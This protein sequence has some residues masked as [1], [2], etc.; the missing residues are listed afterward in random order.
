MTFTY[1]LQMGYLKY[2][3][4]SKVVVRNEKHLQK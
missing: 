1:T 3:K 2:G 4:I